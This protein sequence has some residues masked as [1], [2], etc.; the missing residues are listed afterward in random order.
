MKRMGRVPFQKG[1]HQRDKNVSGTV[2]FREEHHHHHLAWGREESPYFLPTKGEEPPE[3]RRK[4]LGK[5]NR[6]QTGLLAL[7]LASTSPPGS[8]KWGQCPGF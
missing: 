3:F 5:D 6:R 1:H 7:A 8:M 4:N 2:A